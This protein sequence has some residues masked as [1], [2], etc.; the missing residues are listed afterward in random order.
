MRNKPGTHYIDD[1]LCDVL[2]AGNGGFWF[3]PSSQLCLHAHTITIDGKDIELSE[4]SF[5]ELKKQ[6]GAK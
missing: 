1:R 2:V 5:Q 3:V 4:Q 6:L